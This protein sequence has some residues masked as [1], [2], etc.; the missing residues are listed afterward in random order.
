MVFRKH[1]PAPRRRSEVAGELQRQSRPLCRRR[2]RYGNVRLARR[3][4]RQLDHPQPELPRDRIPNKC[5]LRPGVF[6]H[7]QRGLG[8]GRERGRL[9][10]VHR[11]PVAGSLKH[12][13]RLLADTGKWIANHKRDFL[14]QHIVAV[15]QDHAA[16]WLDGQHHFPRGHLQR[17]GG[18]PVGPRALGVHIVR[19]DI[20]IGA[21]QPALLVEL[22]LVRQHAAAAV[23]EGHL[24]ASLLLEFPGRFLDR[25]FDAGRA[26]NDQRLPGAPAAISIAIHQKHQRTHQHRGQHEPRK[27]ALAVA[28]V[29]VVRFPHRSCFA[30]ADHAASDSPKQV[31]KKTCPPAA[32]GNHDGTC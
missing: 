27:S 8:H 25:F 30:A 2:D 22:E 4:F 17:L 21:G 19:C 20:D 16:A 3:Q 15:G 24:R 13:F 31:C 14:R 23:L 29:F 12:F 9:G 1:L 7:R 26:V 6:L 10:R 32:T 5:R 28:A 11:R 18:Q